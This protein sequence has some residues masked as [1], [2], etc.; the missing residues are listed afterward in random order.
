MSD[1]D[2]NNMYSLSI[3]HRSPGGNSQLTICIPYGC[4]TKEAREAY[5]QAIEELKGHFESR[6]KEPL[7][8]GTVRW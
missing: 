1:T 3:I 6:W 2:P 7:F 8:G 4:S 5:Q